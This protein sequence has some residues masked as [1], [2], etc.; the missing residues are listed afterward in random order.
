MHGVG[1]IGYLDPSDTAGGL[2]PKTRQE[3][4]YKLRRV[5]FDS[6]VELEQPDGQTFMFE[7]F[8]LERFLKQV[9][10]MEEEPRI[11]LVDLVWNFLRAAWNNKTNRVWCFEEIREV[12]RANT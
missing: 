10:V 5:A 9:L 11:R 6:E 4:V 1:T 3:G 7:I 8:E 2:K 12:R